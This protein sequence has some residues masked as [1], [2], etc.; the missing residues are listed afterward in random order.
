MV[1]ASIAWAAYNSIAAVFALVRPIS[2]KWE[3]INATIRKKVNISMRLLT[4]PAR[5][6]LSQMKYK[7]TRQEGKDVM[8]AQTVHL[9][10]IVWHSS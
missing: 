5:F 7:K 4:Y 8:K 3:H 6:T 1:P 10:T 2:L 9:F